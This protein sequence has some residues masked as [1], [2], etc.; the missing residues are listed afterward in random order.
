[1]RAGIFLTLLIC[2]PLWMGCEAGGPTPFES[3]FEASRNAYAG[4]ANTAPT[5]ACIQWT[6]ATPPPCACPGGGQILASEVQGRRTSQLVNCRVGT[7]IFN[8][9]IRE[10]PGE[11]SGY[12]YDFDNF[13]ECDRYRFNSPVLCIGNFDVSCAGFP[14]SCSYDGFDAS[15]YCPYSCSGPE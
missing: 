13:G 8:G 5:Q 1:M 4:L 10:E 11:S 12:D 6:G 7:Q 14:D 15:G 9:S 3:A 2:V